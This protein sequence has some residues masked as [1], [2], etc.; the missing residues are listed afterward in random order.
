VRVAGD[1]RVSIRVR[2]TS[3]C[4]GTLRLVEQRRGG[5]ERIV[6]HADFATAP[7]TITLRP[8][9]A[10]Y[11]RAL[12]GCSGGLRVIAKVYRPGDGAKGLGAFRILSRSRCRRTGGPAFGP[13]QP[14][15]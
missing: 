3:G 5:R 2:C 13:P 1:R 14:W 15:P 8:R 6:G 4:R 12:A 10:S 7:R 9:I 11:A